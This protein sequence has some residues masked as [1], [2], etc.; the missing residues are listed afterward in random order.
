MFSLCTPWHALAFTA[1]AAVSLVTPGR[2]GWFIA[3]INATATLNKK[4]YEASVKIK[5]K[6]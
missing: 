4:L 1:T 5:S 3:L 2:D 6:I